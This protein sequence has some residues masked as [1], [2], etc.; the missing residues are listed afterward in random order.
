MNSISVLHIDLF[1]QDKNTSDF[2]FNTMQNH[3]A[4]SHR[5][6]DKLNSQDF[7]MHSSQGENE[8]T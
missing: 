7:C 8:N 2:Y 3:L 1:Q 6:I 5:H 4:T